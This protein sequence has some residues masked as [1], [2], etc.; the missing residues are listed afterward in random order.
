MADKTLAVTTPWHPTLQRPFAGS[1][2]QATTTAVRDLFARVDLYNTEDWTG[3]A[4]PVQA[5]MVRKGYAAL[6]SGPSPRIGLTAR[7]ADEG[8]WVTDIPTPV[9]P[10]KHYA[11]WALSHESVLRPVLGS[12]R[13][14]ADV[15]HGHVGIYGGWLAH[16]F[17]RPDARVVFTEH[18]SFLGKILGQPRSRA[19]YAEVM[20]RADAVLCVSEK[21][22]NELLGAFPGHAAKIQVLPNA[23]EIEAMPFRPEPVT[24]LHRWIYIG[25]VVAAKGVGE[26]VE[27]FAIAAKDEPELRL[28]ILGTGP[29]VEPLRARAA[30]LDLSGRIAFHD[31]VPPQRVFEFLHAHDLLVHP[32]KSETFGMT[33]VEAVGS[34]MPVLVTRC[35]GPEETLAGLDGVAGLLIDV[36]PDPQVIVDG[37]RRLA[38]QAAQLDPARARAELI[39]RYG[40]RAVAAR[41]AEVY[42]VEGSA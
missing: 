11:D 27:A 22:R 20:D 25:K 18:A 1:F 17:A 38:T 7:R 6:T 4:D 12:G 21:L 28:T 32:S 24:A 29:L 16:R 33:T 40:S 15:V 31:S 26:L 10:K 14:E 30:E 39:G 41:L 36:S 19:M 13:F 42:G 34:G 2:V 9:T 35:G 23:V 37:Y 8:Y 3:P 5:R